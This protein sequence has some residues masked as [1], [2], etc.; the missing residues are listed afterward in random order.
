M[1]ADTLHN[2]SSIPL[3]Y[4]IPNEVFLIA[5]MTLDKLL[6]LRREVQ[7]AYPVEDA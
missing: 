5:G 1:Y 2:A 6:L 3:T 4:S 7:T